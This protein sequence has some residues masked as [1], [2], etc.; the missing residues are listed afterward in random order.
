MA[1]NLTYMSGAESF[2][3]FYIQLMKDE[4]LLEMLTKAKDMQ[5]TNR[6]GLSSSIAG[7]DQLCL[8]D[9]EQRAGLLSLFVKIA[10]KKNGTKLEPS[11]I[12]NY[13]KQIQR[14]LKA[15]ETSDVDGN[16]S[17]AKSAAYSGLRI[18]L[19]RAHMERA[20]DHV[21]SG[22]D[23]G[24]NQVVIGQDHNVRVASP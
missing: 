17:L 7:V 3:R 23:F 15:N 16:W 11:V 10:H 2:N 19:R 1:L 12:S 8:L 5:L 13:T 6:M 9:H 24:Q 14:Y 20:G 18:A 4:S 22:D 21:M